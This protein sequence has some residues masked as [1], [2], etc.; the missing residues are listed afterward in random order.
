MPKTAISRPEA[1]TVEFETRRVERGASSAWPR[2]Y[3]RI[4]KDERIPHFAL[5]FGRRSKR[6]PRGH[7]IDIPNALIGRFRV[8]MQ[9]FCGT[10]SKNLAAVAGTSPG[11]TRAAITL[12]SS[13]R[14]SPQA[15]APTR[16]AHTASWEA[17]K[18]GRRN[19]ALARL[20]PSPRISDRLG[21]KESVSA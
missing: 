7:C 2:T 5:N 13:G 8:F 16:S 17:L 18:C 14:C 12:T 21:P 20:L 3:E 10:A 6:T 19:Q 9:P 1:S 4:A 11:T 15:L